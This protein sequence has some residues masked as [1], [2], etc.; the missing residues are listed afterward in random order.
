MGNEKMNELE[1]FIVEAYVNDFIEKFEKAAKPL[2][3]LLLNTDV[4]FKK[5][6]EFIILYGNLH[7]SN[8]SEKNIDDF[9]KKELKS[10]AIK[11]YLE[12]I[13]NIKNEIG[14]LKDFK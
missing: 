2:S 8:T 7:L 14:Y 1:N 13:N 5:L 11:Q 9:L 4:V 10:Q 6:K 12:K 3:D